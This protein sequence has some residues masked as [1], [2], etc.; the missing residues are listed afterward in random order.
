[1]TESIIGSGLFRLRFLLLAL[2]LLGF[3]S[4]FVLL[5]APALAVA[6][7]QLSAFHQGRSA[8]VFGVVLYA[9]PKRLRLCHGAAC[10]DAVFSRELPDGFLGRRVWVKGVYR[11]NTFFASGAP[12]VDVVG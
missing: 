12:D 5:P 11:G 7:S 1:M 10:V 3:A 6:V 8:V 9:S 2:A 4:V